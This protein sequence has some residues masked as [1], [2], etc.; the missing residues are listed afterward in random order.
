VTKSAG[1]AQIQVNSSTLQFLVNGN[2]DDVTWSYTIK[3]LP[4]VDHS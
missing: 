1:D 4:V 2:G 3:T